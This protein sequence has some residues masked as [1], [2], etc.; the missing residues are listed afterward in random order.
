MKVD[1]LSCRVI[2]I[3]VY[4]NN[5]RIYT[6]HI[7][8]ALWLSAFYKSE[9]VKNKLG[10]C[11][12]G[13]SYIERIASRVTPVKDEF[14]NLKLCPI[15]QV[16]I[17]ARNNCSVTK[18]HTVDTH[19]HNP[20][21]D[22][23]FVQIALFYSQILSFGGNIYRLNPLRNLWEMSRYADHNSSS[24]YIDNNNGNDD[25]GNDDHDH[26]HHHHHRQQRRRIPQQHHHD[27]RQQPHSSSSRNGNDIVD[28]HHH[29]Q[30]TI[31]GMCVFF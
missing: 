3:N 15:G 6:S 18:I 19:S 8:L 31:N 4:N 17:T 21:T 13:A 26:H 28:D 29:Q 2:H 5:K 1:Q 12:D 11:R 16:H 25:D 30:T 22:A 24:I 9:S 14:V 10:Y 20:I 23:A 27:H 7:S